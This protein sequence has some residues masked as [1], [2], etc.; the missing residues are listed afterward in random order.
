MIVLIYDIFSSQSFL[1]IIDLLAILPYFITLV[2]ATIE[3]NTHL[4][5]QTATIL[6]L[7]VNA[8]TWQ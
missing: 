2:V 5:P 4:R 6:R 3:T 8:V 7:D 1:N